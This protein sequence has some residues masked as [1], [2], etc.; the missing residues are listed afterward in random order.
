MSKTAKSSNRLMTSSTRTESD[1]YN[2]ATSTDAFSKYKT[3]NCAPSKV[4]IKLNRDACTFG[5]LAKKLEKE[6]GR[7]KNLTKKLE[8]RILLNLLTI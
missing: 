7:F 2:L 6:E 4:K 8:V 1:I 5:N 3:T